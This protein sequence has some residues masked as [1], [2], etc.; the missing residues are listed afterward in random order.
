MT[1]SWGDVPRG[2]RWRRSPRRAWLVMPAG[3]HEVV[4]F[5][6]PVLELMTESRTPLRP[7][8]RGARART[9][10]RERFDERAFL[11]RLREDDPTRGRSAT[12]CST[13]A[14]SPG[15]GNIWKAEG[16][17]AA[18]VDPWRPAGDGRD[19]EVL[20]IVRAVRPQMQRV[21]AR[22]AAQDRHRVVYGATAG[23]ARA[24]ATPHPAR[25]QGDDNRT[26]YWCPDAE[27]QRVSRVGHKGADHVAP[28]N[29][30]ASFEAALEHGVDMIEFD[31]LRDRATGRPA[32]LAHDYADP[33]GASCLTLEEGLD[34][35]AGEAYA[36][37][38]L[39]VDLKLPGYEGRVVEGLARAR[40]ARA[41]AGARRALGA[42]SALGELAP[43]LRRGWSSRAR[44]DRLH[45]AGDA[46]VARPRRRSGAPRLPAAAAGRSAPAAARR[47][48]SHPAHV[49]PACWWP[50]AAPAARSTCGRWTTPSR[51]RLEALGVDGVITNDPRL[52]TP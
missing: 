40:P 26:T 49:S 32:V 39:D 51:A 50:S 1:G 19:D 2:Q 10:S 24:A 46:R 27:C 36:G 16:C 22:R 9:S 3:D 33:R 18:G 45:A 37:V 11:R 38:E 41:L 8:P 13:S 23:P 43:A 21:R 31:V 44:K 12:R 47:S 25:G 20:A 5:D 17:F 14:A 6:G 15:I 30:L 34:H 4:Q 52:F 35:F 29:T 7:A 28:G 48:W 42:S